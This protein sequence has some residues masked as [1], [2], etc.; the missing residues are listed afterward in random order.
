MPRPLPAALLLL[1]AC[2]AGCGAGDP[3][4]RGSQPELRFTDVTD[5]SGIVLANVSGDAGRKTAIP[6]T[7]GQGAAAIDYDGD[8]R[9]D[10]FVA[11]GDSF[12][13]DRPTR[14]ALYRNLGGFEFEDVTAEAGLMFRAWAHGAYRVDFDADG[15]PDLYV[16]IYRGPNRFFRNMGDGT[17]E[18]AAAT[19]GGRDPGPSTA[20]AF[21]D[22]DRDG[23][24]DLYVGN[25]VHYDP[26]DPPNQGR[27]CEWRGLQVLCGPKGTRPAADSFWENRNGVLVEAGEPFGFAAVAPSYTLGLVSGDFDDDGDAD[28]YA[29]ND[30]EANYLFENLGNRRF[31]EVGALRGLDRN[32][33]GRPQAGMGVDFADVDNDGRFDIFVTNFS[34]DSN[35]L[36]RNRATP[37]GQTLFEDATNQM[38][39]GME[40]YPYLS[41]GTRMVDVDRDGWLDIVT[42]SGHVYPEVDRLPVG[43]SYAQP[44]QVFRN[45]GTDAAGAVRFELFDPAAGDAFSK[46]AVSRGLAVADLD[47]DGDPDM[48]V[49]EMDETPT[50][51]RNDTPRPGHWIGFTLRGAAG[52]VEAIGARVEVEDSNGVIRLRERTGG[53]SYLSSDDPRLLFGLGA[54]D[55]AI[56][57]ATVRWPSGLKTVHVG[58][59]CDRYW[60]LE[61]SPRNG[62][63]T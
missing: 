50:L 51:I 19:W 40:S 36:Y 62:G 63:K 46:S 21:F 17:F 4:G 5:G 10:L 12:A 9:L 38:L 53:G 24:L 33:D 15:R 8:G 13:G 29:A 59:E 32:E 20:A 41:W 27:P 6:E 2:C 55:G 43:T 56:R 39:L 23:D 1:A 47:D 14:P 58:L 54:A 44:N 49:V 61:E 37:G 26:D 52:N 34:H 42:V 28:L 22:A 57:R 16:T 48:L 18:D 60:L 35:T 7:L 45:R 25:Y 3:T 31:R 30:S 11:N